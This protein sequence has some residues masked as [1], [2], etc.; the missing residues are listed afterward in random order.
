MESIRGASMMVSHVNP[1][2]NQIRELH[3]FLIF[4]D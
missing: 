4:A 2:S 3:Q 1:V